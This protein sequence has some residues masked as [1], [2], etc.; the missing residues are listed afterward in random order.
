MSDF[1]IGNEMLAKTTEFFSNIVGSLNN[2]CITT[3]PVSLIVLGDHTHY[4]DGILISTSINVHWF[5]VVKKREDK[6]VNFYSAEK[7]I[8]ES[9]NLDDLDKVHVEEFKLLKGITSILYSQNLISTGFDCVIN[10]NCAN[11]FGLGSFAALEMAFISNVRKHFEL[12]M[13]DQLLFDIVRK[14][15]LNL[16]GKISNVAH[17][18]TCLYGKK[19]Q[20][21]H[22]DLRTK[23]YSSFS[24]NGQD[25]SLVICDTK[26]RIESV[27][28]ICNERIE[29]CEVGT[30]GL[31]LY[32]W[33]VKNLR[34]VNPDFL[35]RH[36]HMLPKKIFNR[37][38]HNVN[39]RKRVEDSSK[40]LR[41]GLLEDFGVLV[42]DSHWGLS[43]D[44]ELSNDKVDFLVSESV[45][46]P[47][48]LCSKM[49]SCSPMRASFN[50]VE[51]SLLQNFTKQI[52]KIYMDKY[53]TILNT[54]TLK[55]TSGVHQIVDKESELS[56]M[57]N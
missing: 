23:N 10:S 49:I 41:K 55:F 8:S 52:N 34:D 16:I 2:A 35:L 38:L 33:N 22:I 9:T 45:K 27:Q 15:E 19:N 44:Y 36:Y 28:K 31:R 5:V 4:N 12:D 40:F 54:S 1:R 11:K 51:T 3:C 20:L 53:N 29:E 43:K 46:L 24:L 7:I 6:L 56:Y 47:G 13:E 42:T 30:K 25:Y 48:V 21:F 39:E 17:H 14:N 18:Y 32:I 50:F 57:N 37:V 26:E